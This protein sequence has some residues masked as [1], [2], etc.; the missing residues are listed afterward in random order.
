MLETGIQSAMPSRHAKSVG[1]ISPIAMRDF[2][3]SRAT[4]PCW[5][6]FFA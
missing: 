2:M 5:A 1:E 6:P 3:S 4:G